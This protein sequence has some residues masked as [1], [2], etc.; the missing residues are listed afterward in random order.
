MPVHLNAFV[1]ADP[2]KCI[3]CK[4]CEVACSLAHTDSEAITVGM[5]DTPLIAKLYLVQTAT[6]TMP[7]QC[8]HCEDAP[9]AQVCPEAAITQVN[10]KI[11]INEK[12]CIGCKTCLM[13]CPFGAIDIVPVYKNGEV[14]S[15]NALKVETAAGF[16]KKELAVASKC[17]LC[18]GR[19][20]GPACIGAC[21]EKALKM[22]VPKQE[23]KQRNINAAINLL[24]FVKN[25]TG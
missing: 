24:D 6:V 5:V 18:A 22:V 19:T 9:C 16:V 1:V 13:A 15:Q 7:I 20:D 12:D 3:G 8:R 4:I 21:P 14:V 25:F 11:L 23:T 10:G 2:N 17:D